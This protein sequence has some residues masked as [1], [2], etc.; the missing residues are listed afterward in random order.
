MNERD[1]TSD[2][3]DE[4]RESPDDGEGQMKRLVVVSNRLPVRLSMDEDGSWAMTR[5]SGGLVTALGPVLSG[6][7]GVW[8]GW[9]GASGE[10]ALEAVRKVEDIG[11]RLHPL[12]LTDDE[13]EGYYHGFSNEVLW[14][15]FHD[16]VTRCN[17]DPSNWP[18]YEQVNRKFAET[19]TV[20]TKADDYVWIQDYHLMLCAKILREMG[21]ER[22]TGFFLHIPFPPL[23]IFL[24]LPWR[25]QILEGLLAH[26]LLG[27]Q[28]VRDKRNFI[29]CVRT[30]MPA[31]RV[32]GGNKAVSDLE[33]LDH[34]VRVGAFPIGI[35]FK[36]FA[37]DAAQEEVSEK[38]WY[39]HEQL[40][41]RKLI[42]GVDRLD[43]TKGLPERISSIG[44][45]LDRHPELQ[46]KF[47]FIQVVVPSRES[48]PEY[49]QLKAEVERRVGE[50]NGRYTRDGWTPIH[51]QYRSLKR[52]ELLGYY[53]TA[54]VALV[55]PLKDGMN[56]VAKEYCACSLE[57]GVLIL[58]EF[59]GAAAQLHQGALMVNPFDQHGLADAIHQA[60][61]MPEDEARERMRK[62]RRN[63]RRQN[64]FWWVDQFLRAAISL[65]LSHFPRLHYFVPTPPAET[66]PE[67]VAAGPA[68]AER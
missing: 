12:A 7:G 64:V 22:R 16:L 5:S 60:L 50:I 26:D 34:R 57:T 66:A 53:R 67:Q 38:A 13:I 19:V 30:L 58:S 11:Y 48:V 29:S 44:H 17:H 68:P 36:S 20:G 47:T 61:S 32:L 35:D 27:F 52:S 23:D 10:D 37:V 24:K 51:Y 1:A 42:L 59:A 55:T 9:P 3:D 45:T 33:T 65:D 6:R 49:Q 2:S 25:F 18:V 56:L 21:V 62:L 8:I 28:T 39:L 46:G 63:V 14:P 4:H 15:L 43:Y 31:V 41:D 40:P 54:E